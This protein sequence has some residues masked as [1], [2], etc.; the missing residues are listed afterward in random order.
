MDVIEVNLSKMNETAVLYKKCSTDLDEMLQDLNTSIHKLQ[1][2]WKGETEKIFST[3]H[4]PKLS[5][6]IKKHMDKIAF[7]E[8]ELRNTINEFQYLETDIKSKLP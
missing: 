8:K 2:Q 4:F 1:E 5:E 6:N 7:L 3:N